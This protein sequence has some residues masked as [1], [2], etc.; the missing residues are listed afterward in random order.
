MAEAQT[1]RGGWEGQ[2]PGKGEKAKCW[3][4]PCLTLSK[5]GQLSL[6]TGRMHPKREI[7]THPQHLVRGA[8]YVRKCL[9]LPFGTVPSL[10]L[11]GIT[12][13]PTPAGEGPGFSAANETQ[14]S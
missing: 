6:G 5:T 14:K 4:I 8:V 7:R 10:G 2:S 13:L 3:A 12:G 11:V 1:P 9:L